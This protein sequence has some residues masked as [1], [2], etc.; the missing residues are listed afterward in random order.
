YGFLADFSASRLDPDMVLKKLTRFHVNGLQFYDW[1]YRHD[2][3]LS[4]TETYIDPLGREMS[5]ASVRALVHAAH[6]HGM[7]A[8]PYLAIYAASAEFWRS[9]PDWALYDQVES[10]IAFG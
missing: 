2:Q 5:L 10:P 7:A 1:Q 4:R 9:H 3:L 8:M 6:R